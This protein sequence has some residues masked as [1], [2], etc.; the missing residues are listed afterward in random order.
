MYYLI[1]LDAEGNMRVTHFSTTKGVEKYLKNHPAVH[2][3]DYILI[4][5][6]VMHNGTIHIFDGR[7]Q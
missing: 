1:H 3:D 7:F 6:S 4:E 2:T 5:G